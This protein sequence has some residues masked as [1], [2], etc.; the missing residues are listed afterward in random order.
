MASEK[1]FNMGQMRM[2][3]TIL[4]I[5]HMCACCS[6]LLTVCSCRR[7]ED[8]AKATQQMEWRRDIVWQRPDTGIHS[9]LCERSSSRPQHSVMSCLRY[10]RRASFCNSVLLYTDL[11]TSSLGLLEVANHY[12][13]HCVSFL[14]GED[15]P[16]L[17]EPALGK[18]K[19]VFVF[20]FFPA[21]STINPNPFSLAEW[22]WKEQDS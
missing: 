2:I 1:V 3:Q 9:A 19:I 15:E 13:Y 22:E 10:W 21:P 6:D 16:K 14:V 4:A 7:Y 18:G 8:E 17:D 5:S 20:G 11:Q 12:T